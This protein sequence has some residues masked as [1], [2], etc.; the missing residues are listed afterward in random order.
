M[1]RWFQCTAC[2]AQKSCSP[3]RETDPSKKGLLQL[4]QHHYADMVQKSVFDGLGPKGIKLSVE[5]AEFRIVE[6]TKSTHFP[7]TPS[8]CRANPAHEQPKCRRRSGNTLFLSRATWPVTWKISS[9]WKS[10]S[11]HC[12]PVLALK[13]D[14]GRVEPVSSTVCYNLCLVMH[15]FAKH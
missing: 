14:P 15:C 8:R 13:Q 3:N 2:Q 10:G 9:L 12:M 6:I 5:P 1:P 4:T 11:W 7:T